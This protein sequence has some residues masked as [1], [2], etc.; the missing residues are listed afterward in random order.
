MRK[1]MRLVI[2][3]VVLF[4]AAS[5][6]PGARAT[7]LARLSLEQMA[8][9]A[10]TVVRAR[11]VSIESRWIGGTIW[12]FSGFEVI[13]TLKGAPAERIVVRLPGGRVGHLMTKVEAVPRFQ[14]GE[15]GFLFLEQTRVGDYSV[16][17]WAE[18]TFRVKPATPGS[19]ATVT[20]DSIA[21]PVFD[22]ETRRFRSEGVRRLP[23]AQFR[24]QL[25]AALVAGSQG[26]V[27]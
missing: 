21:F 19:A 9:A 2:G 3:V 8:Q 16:S 26:R 17:A 20:Q 15:E 7:T 24:E 23:V 4:F 27:R 12:T 22:A 18:G 14:P 6:V 11:C 10:D 1:S 25:Q 5:A 13:E